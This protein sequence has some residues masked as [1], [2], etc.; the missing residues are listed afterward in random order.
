MHKVQFSNGV[1]GYDRRWGRP[2]RRRDFV[3]LLGGGAVAWSLAARSQ[4]ADRIARVGFFRADGSVPPFWTAALLALS[5]L[6]APSVPHAQQSG[7]IWRIGIIAA[8]S[9]VP[10]MRSV[11]YPPLI[12]ACATPATKRAAMSCSSSDPLRDIL[13]GYQVSLRNWWR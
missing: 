10:F 11:V 6:A 7:K 8:L 2:M 13:S 4:P 12:M 9:P 3:T 5:I 1:V